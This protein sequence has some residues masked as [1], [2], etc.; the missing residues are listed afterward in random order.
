MPVPTAAQDLPAESPK[1][2]CKLCPGRG[3]LCERATLRAGGSNSHHRIALQ[4]RSPVE[5]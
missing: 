5:T 3:R 4:A 1:H 2:V